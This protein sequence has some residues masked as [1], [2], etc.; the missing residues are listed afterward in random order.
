[1]NVGNADLE[2]FLGRQED[3]CKML[4]VY[5]KIA[6]IAVENTCFS[7]AEIVIKSF[8]NR[9]SGGKSSFTFTKRKF[10]NEKVVFKTRL[11]I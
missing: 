8:I 10:M 3:G 4:E 11:A 2:V 1:M 6:V 5:L 9:S 7:R